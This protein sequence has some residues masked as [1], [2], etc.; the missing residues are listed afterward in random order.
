MCNSLPC[1]R[2]HSSQAWCAQSLRRLHR[3]AGDNVDLCPAFLVHSMRDNRPTAAR[4]ERLPGSIHY[5]S[6]RNG[7]SRKGQ[8]CWGDFEV[9][10]LRAEQVLHPTVS[11][12]RYGT[13]AAEGGRVFR[14]GGADIADFVQSLLGSSFKITQ[15]HGK[16]QSVTNL[17][18]IIAT[19]PSAA[20]ATACT[21]S[22][23]S[24]PGC[25]HHGFPQT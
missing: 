3:P 6:P 22:R 20:S 9:T 7:K 1:I 8:Q 24:S 25:G 2:L 21:R 5:L 11:S 23:S 17:S 16:V 15:D 13:L 10:K 14:S 19:D 12:R 4:N 18:A